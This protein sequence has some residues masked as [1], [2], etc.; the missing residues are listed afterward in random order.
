MYKTC[1]LNKFTPWISQLHSTWFLQN[2]KE[3]YIYGDWKGIGEASLILECKSLT[4]GWISISLYKVVV[5]STFVLTFLYSTFVLT[6][7]ILHLYVCMVGIMAPG[8]TSGL[9]GSVNV[10]RGA[11]LLVP[12]WQCIS[13]SVFYIKADMSPLRH[14]DLRIY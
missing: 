11:L 8:L 6:F 10:H 1:I 2:L 12:Q 14:L 3:L 5:D 13:S 7:C 9:Q 4:L